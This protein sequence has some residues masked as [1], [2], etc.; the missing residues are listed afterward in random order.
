M[1]VHHTQTGKKFD[2]K[3]VVITGG[4]GVLCA[5]LCYSLA[6]EGARIAILDINAHAADEL[7]QKIIQ[8][9]GEA[10]AL[11]SRLLRKPSFTPTEAWIY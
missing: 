8:S 9:G 10:I 5:P 7:A 2:G 6:V 3:I 1:N 11:T 4:A